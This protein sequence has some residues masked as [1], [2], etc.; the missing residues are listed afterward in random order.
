MTTAMQNQKAAVETGQWL[1]Y[2]YNPELA[3]RG[4]NPMQLTLA[5]R[6]VL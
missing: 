3:A 4:E 6:S 2:R 5:L 1:L